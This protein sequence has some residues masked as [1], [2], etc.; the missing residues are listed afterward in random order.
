MTGAGS[1]RPPAHTARRLGL[2]GIL[3]PVVLRISAAH[4][5]AHVGVRPAPESR[6]V[7]RHLNGTLRGREQLES[8]GNL[9]VADARR[10]LE[11]ENLLQS[12]GHDWSALIEIVDTDVG[13]ARH[14]QM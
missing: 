5:L 13:A 8:D 1:L 10:L 3:R 11:S 6:Q 14:L 4:I 9:A 7:A 12:H 2:Q